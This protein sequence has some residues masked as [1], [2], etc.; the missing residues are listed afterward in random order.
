MPSPLAILRR[1]PDL[2]ALKNADIENL[3]SHTKPHDFAP[4]NPILSVEKPSDS[5]FFL[6]DGTV[7]VWKDDEIGVRLNL[8]TRGVGEILGEIHA[9]DGEGHSVNVEAAET[10]QALA[11]RLDD[12][13]H[14]YLTNPRFAWA[15]G[16]LA[17][18][19]A[20]FSTRVIEINRLEVSLRVVAWLL[21]IARPHCTPDS[22]CAVVPTRLTQ[23]NLAEMV[24]ASRERVNDVVGA[25]KKQGVLSFDTTQH[26]TIHD[27]ARLQTMLDTLTPPALD[28]SINP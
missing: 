7:T 5:V 19:R 11:L 21:E 10:C 28:N 20:R 18:R 12:F 6:L 23:T 17:A 24:G 8:G 22:N 2:R 9:L 27:L 26:L 16:R 15:M 3:F 13:K 4:D 14:L 1:F 25:L